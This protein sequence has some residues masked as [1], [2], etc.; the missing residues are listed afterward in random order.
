V[1][2]RVARTRGPGEI[3]R[4]RVDRPAGAGRKAEAADSPLGMT[5]FGV[6]RRCARM[7][8]GHGMPCPTDELAL[9]YTD[10]ADG[11]AARGKPRESGASVVPVE[12]GKCGLRGR[13]LDLALRRIRLAKEKARR[14]K[15]LA[16]LFD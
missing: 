6:S 4:L 5:T 2:R 8:F 10:R 11:A 12:R 7:G 14:E 1:R 9:D 15:D 3:P 13:V 16:G